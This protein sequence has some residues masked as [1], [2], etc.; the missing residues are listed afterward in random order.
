MTLAM[1]IVPA[2]AAAVLSYLLT[3]FAGRFAVLVGAVD[4][5]GP[6]K[7]H[8]RPIPRLGGIAVV[9]SIVIVVVA[10]FGSLATD[11]WA[12]VRPLWLAIG[13]VIYFSCASIILRGTLL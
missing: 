4:M 1:F 6:R 8:Q 5:P 13:L 7:V 10:A 12:S 11:A 3:P 9:A 2:F